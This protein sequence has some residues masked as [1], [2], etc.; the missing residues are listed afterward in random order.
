MLNHLGLLDLGMLQRLQMIVRVFLGA[1]ELISSSL[2]LS[3][4]YYLHILLVGYI[5][6]STFWRF[7]MMLVSLFY[8]FENLVMVLFIF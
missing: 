4:F 1:L 2:F 5:Y 6:I 3:F 8:Y 7:R